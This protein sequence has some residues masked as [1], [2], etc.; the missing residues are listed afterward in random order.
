MYNTPFTRLYKKLE[1]IACQALGKPTG[2]YEFIFN[3]GGIQ[4]RICKDDKDLIKLMIDDCKQGWRYKIKRIIC[5]MAEGKLKSF[6]LV[7]L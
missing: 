3:Q 7:T 2:T 6:R 1:Q 4:N 5:H